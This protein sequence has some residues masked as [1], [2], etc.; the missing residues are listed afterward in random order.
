MTKIQ[1]IQIKAIPKYGLDYFRPLSVNKKGGEMQK[2]WV[3][4]FACV[5]VKAVHLEIA[6]DLSTE[7]F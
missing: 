4:L 1:V 7:E 3:C 5:V 2:F 6:D